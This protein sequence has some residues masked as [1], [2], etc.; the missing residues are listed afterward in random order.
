MTFQSLLSIFHYTHPPNDL[1]RSHDIDLCLS[2]HFILSLQSLSWHCV[3]SMFGILSHPLHGLCASHLENVSTSQSLLS[4][5]AVV[6][7]LSPLSLIVS[8]KL[9]LVVSPKPLHQS[10]F[11]AAPSHWYR[12]MYSQVSPLRSKN[13]ALQHCLFSQSNFRHN[14]VPEN[15]FYRWDPS[16]FSYCFHS[17][18]GPFYYSISSSL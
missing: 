7:Q 5:L 16:S 9:H 14:V 13:K 10:V 6:F 12:G 18:V 1:K 11:W 3:T 17:L 15:C 2:R 8:Y 4:C